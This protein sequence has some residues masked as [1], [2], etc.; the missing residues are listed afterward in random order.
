[1]QVE[2]DRSEAPNAI[3]NDLGAIFVSLELIPARAEADSQEGL[4]EA[5]NRGGSGEVA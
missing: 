4:N 3:R 1:M 2:A 5:A